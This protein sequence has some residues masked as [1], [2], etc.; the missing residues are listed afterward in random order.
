MRKVPFHYWLTCMFFTL[1]PG[2]LMA[3]QSDTNTLSQE[4]FRQIFNGRDLTGWDGDMRFWRVENGAIVGETTPGVKT[5]GS[6]F[7]IW[8]AG[9]LKDFELRLS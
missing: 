9:E 8:T 3:A 4:G 7:L 5:E 1:D 6:T 2:W